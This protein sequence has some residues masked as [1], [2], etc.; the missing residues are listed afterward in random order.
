MRATQSA[1]YTLTA[2]F[3]V[4]CYVG[5]MRYAFTLLNRWNI[6]VSDVFGVTLSDV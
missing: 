5:K 6:N 2:F 4:T 3:S 1:G